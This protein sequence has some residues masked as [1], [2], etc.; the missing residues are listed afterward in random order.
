M[1]LDSFE[2][3][4]RKF[5]ARV[6]PML[7]E[8]EQSKRTPEKKAEELKLDAAIHAPLA[9]APDAT[10]EDKA[11]AELALE[12]HAAAEKLAAEAVRQAAMTDEERAAL[13]AEIHKP[14]PPADPDDPTRRKIVRPGAVKPAEP[15]PPAAS[16][17][18][19]EDGKASLGPGPTIQQWVAA[20][21]KASTYPPKH[22]KSSSTP[23]EIATAVAA[24]QATT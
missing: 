19:T 4:F 2:K 21:Y 9:P 12:D 7:W 6:E 17:F 15:L 23:E 16:D 14:L 5:K 1:D 24:E 10:D 18:E 22:Y 11:A 13:D 8:W 3:E 20:G